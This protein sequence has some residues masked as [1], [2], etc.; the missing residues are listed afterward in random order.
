MKDLHNHLMYGIDDGSRS[1]KESKELLK[2]LEERG[3]SEILLTPHFIRDSEYS[4]NNRE[5]K[6]ILDIL[7]KETSIKL[8]I[9][10]EVYI[11]DKIIDYINNGYISTINNSRYVLIELSLYNRI[12]NYM[13][14]I[15]DLINSGYIPVI[16]HVERYHYIKLEEIIKLNDMGCLFQS[17]LGS[18]LGRY[19][20][21][22]TRNLIL[23]LK[24][25]IINVFGT[26]IHRTVYDIN[27][28][29]NILKKYTSEDYYND[30][31][32]NNFN[33]IINNKE[34]SKYEVVKSKFI[35]KEKIL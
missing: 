4:S 31:I 2:K 11:D 35:G 32:V 15:F 13:D 30:L 17:N 5:K 9:G 23:L 26:D 24:K 33:N 29:L 7:Q 8:Y 20:K 1:L 10:N 16:A 19:G 27:K 12:N 14:I 3:V 28:A 21:N 22:T 25:R 34:V 18:L 6:V